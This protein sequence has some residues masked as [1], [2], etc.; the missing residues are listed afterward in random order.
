MAKKKSAAPKKLDDRQSRKEE[1][2]SA[3]MSAVVERLRE[4]AARMAGLVRAMEDGQVD[5]V[6]IDG[7]QML[8]RGI[9]QIENFIDNASRSIRE[10]RT[11]NSPL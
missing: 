4:Q 3:R 11:R 8:Q 7:H 5:R 9:N 2:S 10:A 1:Y 6:P